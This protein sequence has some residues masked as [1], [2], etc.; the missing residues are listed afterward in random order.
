V[1]SSTAIA[2]LLI[3]VAV[4]A[5]QYSQ[6]HATLPAYGVGYVG[7]VNPSAVSGEQFDKLLKLNEQ[8]VAY[9][10]ATYELLSGTAKQGAK[11][12]DPLA[13]AQ[14]RCANCHTPSS[15]KGDF[16]LFAAAEQT[17]LNALNRADKARL[18]KVID[19]GTM[20]KGGPSLS[21]DEKAAILSLCKE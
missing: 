9:Q 20:P 19:A 2:C 16:I 5:S 7:G 12:L 4:A 6:Q 8:S 1:K 3:V 13:V 21:P 18:K 11:R 17:A 14:A 15:A 10:K